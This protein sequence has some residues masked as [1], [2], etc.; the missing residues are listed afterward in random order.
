MEL[1]FEPISLEKQTAYLDKLAQCKQVS[2]D[3][4]F[5]NLFGWGDEYGLSWAFNERLVWIKQQR[6]RPAYWAPIGDWEN[7]D[8]N[9][10]LE[11]QN[12]VFTRV[13]EKLTQIWKDW[14]GNRMAFEEVRN[15]WDYIY[16]INELIELKGNRFHKKK[17]LLNQFLKKY[18]S[19]YI[20]FGP[21]LIEP[22]MAMQADWCN[23]RDCESSEV[24]MAENRSVLKILMN[25]DR[26]IGLT[27]GA[28]M[29]E[30]MIVAYTIGERITDDTVVVHYE[31]GCPDYKGVYQAINQMFLA[32]S[33]P[34]YRYVNREQDLGEKGLRKAK[35]SYNPV[36]FLRKYRVTVT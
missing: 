15:H 24:L 11:N 31:K 18:E 26:L 33:A 4:S 21:E 1:E 19:R 29:V 23:W 32:N 6:P 9:R 22:A 20:D 8:W 7:T 34:D 16:E 30:D 13:P 2:S 35:L 10:V 27:G 17:N 14:L 3:Y 28:I 25:W 12:C 36:D 5:S